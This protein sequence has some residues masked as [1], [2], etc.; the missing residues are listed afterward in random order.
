M[1]I[2]GR[3]GHDKINAAYAYGG[4]PL[5]KR[6]VANLL[7][8]PINHYM[9]VD[10]QGFIKVVDMLG[11]WIWMWNRTWTTKIPMRT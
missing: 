4:V 10:W 9:Q 8:V 5:A 1:T 11:A 7:Q 3:R 6:T 2:P